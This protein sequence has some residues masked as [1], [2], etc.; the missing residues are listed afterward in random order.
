[1][2]DID[3]N[4]CKCGEPGAPDHTCPYDADVN[5]ND[6]SECNCCKGCTDDCA[7]DV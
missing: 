1:M 5:N 2:N 7:M 6:D 3:E 4:I